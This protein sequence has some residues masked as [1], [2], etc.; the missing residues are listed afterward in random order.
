MPGPVHQVIGGKD[1][2][3]TLRAAG[4]D[5]KDLKTVHRQ[6]AQVA[7]NAAAQKA[8]EVSGRLRATIRAAGTQTAGI[9][10]V[11]NNT[12]V[13]YAPVVHWGWPKHHIKPN[14]FAVEGAQSSEPV[15]L[16]LY[17]RHIDRT[18]SQVKGK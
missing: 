18:L 17:E 1:L 13:P 8:P 3:K 6:S 12:R 11:G 5:M 14:P 4:V 15:W 2:R 7:A 16:P 10:R 9:V